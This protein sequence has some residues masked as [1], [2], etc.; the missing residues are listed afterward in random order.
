V[1]GA[2]PLLSLEGEVRVDSSSS[3]MDIFS[4][5]VGVE[6]MLFSTPLSQICYNSFRDNVANIFFSLL[7]WVGFVKIQTSNI[8]AV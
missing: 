4:F 1:R 7:V 8:V 3:R 2:S 6:R 5:G